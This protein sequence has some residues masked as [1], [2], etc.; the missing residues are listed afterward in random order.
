M[1]YLPCTI[2]CFDYVGCYMKDG[3]D[4]KWISGEDEGEDE[5]HTIVLKKINGWG[6]ILCFGWVYLQKIKVDESKMEG[7]A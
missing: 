6:H 3:A 7:E 1:Q 4:I 5:I 2:I